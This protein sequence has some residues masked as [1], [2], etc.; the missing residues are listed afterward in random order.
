MELKLKRLREREEKKLEENARREATRNKEREGT[1]RVAVAVEISKRGT[2]CMRPVKR[3]GEDGDLRRRD[4]NG[5]GRAAMRLRVLQHP[6]IDRLDN[7]SSS[8]P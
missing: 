2:E 8:P 7:T 3:D 6:T 1:V 5:E 4:S